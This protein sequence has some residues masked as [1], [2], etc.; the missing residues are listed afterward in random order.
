MSK[1]RSSRKKSAFSPTSAGCAM[2]RFSTTAASSSSPITRT[3]SLCTPIS[4]RGPDP[5]ATR[6]K[7]GDT[8]APA[9]W[10]PRE[11]ARQKVD[12]VLCRGAAHVGPAL[13]AEFDG[14]RARRPA[15]FGEPEA[16]PPLGLRFRP[17]RPGDAGD[18]DSEAGL[19]AVESPLGHLRRDLLGHRA[20]VV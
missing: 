20:M 13:R 17:P 12:C 10:L 7:A 18:G 14:F 5:R 11:G 16:D 3:A 15:G 8:T 4:P 2:S 6:W 19:R 1:D 9:F